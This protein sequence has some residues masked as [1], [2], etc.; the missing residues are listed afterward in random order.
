MMKSHNSCKAHNV[1]LINLITQTY[2]AQNIG[3]IKTLSL[4]TCE[5]E[6]VVLLSQNLD[7]LIRTVSTFA[8]QRYIIVN[9]K[10]IKLLCALSTAG[11]TLPSFGWR[12]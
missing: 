6:H 11:C 12:R 2:T 7:Y 5:H 3:L 1:R 8:I 4:K 10:I 9:N